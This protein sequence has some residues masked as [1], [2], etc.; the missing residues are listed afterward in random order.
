MPNGKEGKIL[1][2]FVARTEADTDERTVTAVISTA[3]VD[4]ENE[5]LVPIRKHYT[6]QKE[7]TG[8]D[9]TAVAVI[10]TDIVDRENEVLVPK[11]VKLD[12][13]LKNPTVLW[14]HDYRGT[15]VGSAKKHW[16]KVGRRFIKAKWEWADTEKAQEIRKLWDGDFLNAVSVGFLPADNGSHPPTTE[17]IKR[18]PEWAA[19]KRIY[20]DWEL[21]EFSIVP[22]PANPEALAAAIRSKELDL[23]GETIKQLDIDD[24]VIV[25]AGTSI[26][27]AI[28]KQKYDCE[29]IECGHKLTSDKHCKDLKCPKCGGQMR[30]VER[31]GPG[32]ESIDE[33]AVLRP[34]P[35]EHACRLKPPNYDSYAR[36]N[37]AQK[38]DGK[39][40]DV[41][42]GIKGGKS[43]IQSL[44]LD[45]KIWTVGAATALC[46]ERGGMFEAAKILVKSK[47]KV[48]KKRIIKRKI[49]L[50][51]I[52]RRTSN[53]T[54]ATLRGKVYLID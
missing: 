30:R 23:S 8:D 47:R 7:S 43:E 50:E 53:R 38:H 27:D 16:V 54:M 17:E 33:Q 52:G 31:P 49:D 5:V 28:D 1:K 32:Q 45:K 6:A 18:R 13:Y 10:S 34:Y 11:G 42:Y 41:I 24:S 39:C 15:P 20:D 48:R 19:A 22:V 46:K 25:Y 12:N 4:R 35:N 26:D 29:C 51:E 44:R 37:C 21:L 3:A 9:N 2:Q 36:K 40:I 14:V